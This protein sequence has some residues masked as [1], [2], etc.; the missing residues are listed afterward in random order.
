MPEI[1]SGALGERSAEAYLKR[2]GYE[3]E[4]RNYRCKYGELDIVARDGSCI[5]IAEVKTRKSHAYGTPAEFV[6]PKKQERLRCAAMDYV[7]YKETEM[8]FDVIE[9]T[10]E[11]YHGRF[12]VKEINHIENAF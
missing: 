6:T 7:G 3:V 10:Y 8:R 1:N 9:I 5:V 2:K 12:L 4:A 11:M